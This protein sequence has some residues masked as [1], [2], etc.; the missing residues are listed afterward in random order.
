[1]GVN[2]LLQRRNSGGTNDDLYPRAHWT[3]IEDKPSTFTPTPH[4]HDGLTFY[5]E[6]NTSGT[7][8][9]WTGTH[10]DI[11]S[12]YAGLVVNYKIGIAGASTTTLNINGLGA[13][14]VY[15]NTS[16]LTTHLGV[17]TIVPLVYSGTGWIW[18]D[19]D[20]D[21]VYTL[22]NSY[23]DLVGEDPVYSYKI[24]AEGA[25]GKLYPLTLESGTGTTKTVSP[26]ELKIGGSIK[27]YI[28]S[29]TINANTLTRY[30]MAESA[31]V[32]GL[33][34]LNS[35]S[36]FTAGIPIYLV[37]II[38]TNGSFKLDASTATSWYTQTLP[39][40]ADGKI[41][42][43]LGVMHDTGR[44]L[45]VHASHPI[46]EYKDSKLRLYV[47]N[48]T[49]PTLKIQ[50]NSVDVGTYDGSSE[51]TINIT[52]SDLDTKNTA[53]ATDTS[54]KIYLVGATAQTANPQTYSHD[55]AYVGTDGCVYS[56]GTKTSVEGHTHTGYEPAVSAG[57]TAQYWRGDK[58]W[59][60][61]PTIPTIPSIMDTTEGN[62]G[63]ATTQRTI[64]AANLKT[65]ILNHS[66]AG[67]RPASDVSAWAKA[68]TKPSYGISEI[69]SRM[70]ED[71]A[72]LY[73]YGEANVPSTMLY[74]GNDGTFEHNGDTVITSGTIGGYQSF[75]PTPL[76]SNI[77]GS[78]TLNSSGYTN[79]FF[80]VTAASTIT[81]PT[82]ATYN[83]PVGTETHFYRA[84]S[85]DVTFSPASGVT[86]TSEGSKR[87][88]NAQY[89][90]A[91]LKKIAANS[92]VLIG[93]LKA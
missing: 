81:I 75:V 85:S 57:T 35:S 63:T 25:N 13:K 7:A 6:G 50:R 88:I 43:H 45:R 27:V 39:T 2:I 90:A 46:Y 17:G 53:G 67:S 61:F 14:T 26:R 21:D 23:Y 55:T 19:Y 30:Y 24:V 62:A 40:T 47:P 87:K 59:V 5:V 70:T 3:N 41:Y 83:H 93:A 36:G 92:W 86:L 42:I 48:H 84:T 64:N 11:T 51:Q 4:S 80:S 44:Y 68:S 31:S 1:M 91:T 89:Q 29:A 10:A 15:R 9:I 28:T 32:N 54:S 58:T 71:S 49:H 79:K 34:T 37:G 82:D 33:Y 78:A 8:G 69:T 16:N 18:A 65:I 52:D 72:G 12:Y 56:N 22:R 74:L 77:T 76:G 38:Q 66:P 20:S 60:A 73:I